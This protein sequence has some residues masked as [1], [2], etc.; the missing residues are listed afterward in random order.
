VHEAD[1]RLTPGYHSGITN[2]KYYF[3]FFDC[4][5]TG[6]FETRSHTLGHITS[7]RVPLDDG[8]ARHS[9][10]YPNTQHTQERD[11]RAVDDYLPLPCF[12]PAMA[13][14]VLCTELQLFICRWRRCALGRE[15]ING[16][17]KL[18]ISPSC[19][20]FGT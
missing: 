2:Q 12:N 11:V 10:C 7:C 18:K 16:W 8:L 17:Y 20:S 1:L 6:L 5:A 3:L 13:Y 15:C 9:D 19:A 14:S 4:D